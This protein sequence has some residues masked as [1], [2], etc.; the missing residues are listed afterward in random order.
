MAQKNWFD[1]NRDSILTGLF[2]AAV[3]AFL[4][5]LSAVASS[6]AMPIFYGFV[7]GA[8]TLLCCA[9]FMVVRRLPSQPPISE[10]N[11]E[12]CV[13]E[14]LDNHKIA[15]RNDPY[16][17]G[18][19]RLRITLDSDCALTVLRSK[20]EYPDYV[21]IICDLGMR[22][23]NQRILEMFTAT[24]KAEILF[25]IKTELARAKVGYAGLVDPPESFHLFRR[26]PIYPTLTEFA[27]LS[28]IGDLEAARNLVFL[29]FLKAKHTI[30][31]ANQ[32]DRRPTSD[33]QAL[34]PPVA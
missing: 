22:G 28:M 27:F 5:Y 11:I 13:R 30:D 34:E 26:V 8:A 6:W 31:Q 23:D 16:P 18:H 25:E 19:F 17:E 3:W 32:T 1:R 9:A 2:V 20:T 15:V 10:K 14:W 24:Q 33:T 4:T 21:Q 29:A 7:A 12:A